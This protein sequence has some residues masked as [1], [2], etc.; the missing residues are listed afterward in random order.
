MHT[1]VVLGGSPWQAEQNEPFPVVEDR[2]WTQRPR[3]KKSTKNFRRKKIF[4]RALTLY[5]QKIRIF[6]K[7]AYFAYFSNCLTPT[8]GPIWKIRIFPYAINSA[9]SDHVYPMPLDFNP[10][11]V[12]PP[13]TFFY[14]KILTSIFRVFPIFLIQKC[15]P[16]HSEG[17]VRS[18]HGL[19]LSDCVF[20]LSLRC[21]WGSR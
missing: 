18:S 7:N 16:R 9:A 12:D 19:G 3:R 10:F 8:A 5:R 2:P 20:T 4:P 15:I 11:R 21:P 13:W 17:G 14:K 6:S 1:K